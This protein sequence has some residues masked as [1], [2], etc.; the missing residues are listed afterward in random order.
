MGFRSNDGHVLH[1][2]DVLLNCGLENSQIDGLAG[3]QFA[4]VELAQP[5]VEAP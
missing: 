1:F 5:I 4:R 2:K 3:T